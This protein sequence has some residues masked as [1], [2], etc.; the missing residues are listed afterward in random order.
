MPCRHG[1]A[2]A[3][4]PGRG[5]WRW[6]SGRWTTSSGSS[7]SS[8]MGSAPRA[9]R[10]LTASTGRAWTT[11]HGRVSSGSADLG[12][13]R[14]DVPAFVGEQGEPGEIDEEAGG[15]HTGQ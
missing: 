14:D 5:S 11:R 4:V 6:S 10:V 8:P 3:W 12:F 9:E 13:E 7:R 15:D 2:S 1:Y